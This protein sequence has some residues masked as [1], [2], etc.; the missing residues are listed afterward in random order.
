MLNKYAHTHVYIYIYIYI[1]IIQKNLVFMVP[2]LN[3]KSIVYVSWSRVRISS[4]LNL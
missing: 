4:N 1:Y 2:I 3:I